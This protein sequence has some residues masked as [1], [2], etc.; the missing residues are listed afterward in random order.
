MLGLVASACG[1]TTSAA[2]SKAP[3]DIT[4]GTLY[5]GSGTFAVQSIPQLAG[6]KFWIKQENSKGGAYVGA[7]KKRIPLKLVTYNDQS[8]TS[9]ASTLYSQLIVQNKVNI[10]VAD[11]GSVLTAPAVTIAEEHHQLLFDP[12]GTGTSFFTPGNKYIALTAD[13]ASSVWPNPLVKLLL[14]KH[15][16]KVAILY[17]TND[18]DASQAAAAKKGLIA[19]GI[20]PVYYQGVPTSTS[21]YGSL[22]QSVKATH[23]T[24]VLEFGY[25]NNDIAYLQA[26]KSAGVKFPMEFAVFPGL[27]PAL[28]ESNVG[29][30]G[31]SY[32]LTYGAPPVITYNNVNLGL[33]TSAFAKA[34][35]PSNPSSINI[36]DTCGYANGLVIQTAL[37]HATNLSQLALRKAVASASGSLKTIWGTFKINAE[38]AQIGETLPIAQ[39]IPSGSTTKVETVYPPASAIHKLVYP[40]P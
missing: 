14:A 37:D 10:L 2:P 4:I 17:N 16:S 7:Y 27:N 22:V 34:F 24:A 26:L 29:K 30:A 19:A 32:V 38:G 12:T 8:S 36:D 9:T 6:L 39:M 23:P 18:F 20:H 25:P 35:D 11:Y 13:P 33:T 21:S 5:A 28:L 31:V 40:M 3:K 1:A 15:I